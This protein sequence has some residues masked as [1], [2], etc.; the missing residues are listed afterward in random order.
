MNSANEP[1]F[2]FRGNDVLLPSLPEAP[3]S[4]ETIRRTFPDIIREGCF[5]RGRD[6]C[7]WFEVAPETPA[8]EGMT[9]ST[10]RGTWGTFGDEWFVRA[11]H[12]YQLMEWE[13]TTRYCSRC[14]ATT[15]THA[16]DRAKQCPSCGFVSYP[17]INPVVIVAIMKGDTILLARNA[18]FPTGRHSVIAGF[19]E[20]GET[21]EETV[22]REIREEVSIEVRDVAY[23]AS[24]PWPFPH[25]LMIGFRATWASGDIRPD[26]QEIVEAGWYGPDS[27]PDIPPHGSIS[28]RLIDAAFADIR[29]RA[30]GNI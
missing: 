24:Q 28:R 3:V 20:A 21:L 27:H 9:F 30:G 16:T 12:A 17:I 6:A 2:V 5:T 7:R 4:G 13:R 14:G 15:G 8:P 22:V 23:V 10:L 18:G 19:V 29:G 26:G 11:G 1:C 25:S